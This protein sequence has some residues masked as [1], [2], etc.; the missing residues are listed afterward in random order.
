MTIISL[1]VGF[2]DRIMALD[3]EYVAM[4]G[5]A[6]LVFVLMVIITVL[7]CTVGTR[8]EGKR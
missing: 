5:M 1:F 7:I 2:V 3:D 6:V 4:I 8:R